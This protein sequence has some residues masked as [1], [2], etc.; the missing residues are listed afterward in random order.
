MHQICAFS[1]SPDSV[2][3]IAVSRWFQSFVRISALNAGMPDSMPLAYMPLFQRDGGMPYRVLS[4][5][6]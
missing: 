6:P 2:R 4:E 1:I 3:W 5:Q